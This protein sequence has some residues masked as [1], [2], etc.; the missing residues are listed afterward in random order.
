MN[1]AK[2]SDGSAHALL[3]PIDLVFGQQCESRLVA[4]YLADK[5]II[6]VSGAA[7][8]SQE[9]SSRCGEQ[10]KCVKRA[11]ST[12]GAGGVPSDYPRQCT[13][14]DVNEQSVMYI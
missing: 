1:C 2:T 6:Q 5:G 14:G 13:T 9:W 7:N 10:I 8:N 12:A 3:Q 11:A 4:D